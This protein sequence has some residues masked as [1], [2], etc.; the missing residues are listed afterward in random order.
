MIFSAS[1]DNWFGTTIGPHQHLQIARYRAAENQKPLLR[2]TST[3]ISAAINFRGQVIEQIPTFVNFNNKNDSY[4][5]QILK[6]KINARSG[7]TPYNESGKYPFLYLI[8]FI[9][10]A[11]I[12]RRFIFD[13]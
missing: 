7:S 2:S 13:K 4:D 1:N 5:G 10:I 11:Q 9:F 12:L 8:L 6:V 3:G